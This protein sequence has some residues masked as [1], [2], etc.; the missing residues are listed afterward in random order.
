[1]TELLA[2]YNLT[3]IAIGLFTFIIIGL[4]HPVCIKAEYYWGT[5]CWWLF[6]LAGLG[7]VAASIM[8]RDVLWSSA[9]GVLAFTCLW[10][11]KELF[12]QRERVCKGW[13]PQ[14]PKRR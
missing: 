10:T 12:D 13:Y 7:A 4:F 5:G 2:Q 8:V 11:I 3:G 1:M 9:L 6:L 14:N